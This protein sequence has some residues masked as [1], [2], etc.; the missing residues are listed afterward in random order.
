M[1]RYLLRLEGLVVFLL[2][3]YG[4]KAAEG[5]W[6][7]FVVLFLAPDLSMIGY[8]VNARAGSTTYD[9]VHTYATPVILLAVGWSIHLPGFIFAGLILAAHIGLDRFLGYGL[10][11]P[12]AFR[13]THIQRV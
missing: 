11:Y 8:L 2:S 13:D 1:V 10:K 4:Y 7:W 3:V 12:T 5:H 6:L 9:L